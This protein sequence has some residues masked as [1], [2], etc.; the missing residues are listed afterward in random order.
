MLEFLPL[1]W[2][3]AYEMAIKLSEKI[4][5]SNF[6]PDVII[7]I[8]RGGLVVA[9]MLSDLL[10]VDSVGSVR[11]RF[12]RQVGKTMDKP[13]VSQPVNIRIENKRVLLCDDVSDTGVSLKAAYEHLL[14]RKP[15]IIKTATL[16]YKPRTI[17]VPDYHV[18]VTSKWIIYPWERRETIN[19][20]IRHFLLENKEISEDDLILKLKV[21]GLDKK[22]IKKFIEW[23]KEDKLL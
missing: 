7:G 16:H 17:F 21:T 15:E 12:Y 5:A 2:D 8:S 1:S 6:V 23:A 9:R 3:E 19:D 10:D 22:L 14:E 18:A 4:R 11:I 13:I 20:L